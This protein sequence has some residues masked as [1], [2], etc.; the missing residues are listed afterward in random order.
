MENQNTVVEIIRGDLSDI[1]K[2]VFKD[3]KY[4]GEAMVLNGS[5]MFLVTPYL[6]IGMTYL[7]SIKLQLPAVWNGTAQV[8]TGIAVILLLAN[9]A[10]VYI[11]AGIQKACPQSMLG[12]LMALFN[13]CSNLILPIGIWVHGIIHEKYVSHLH[14]I[15]LTISILTILTAIKGKSVYFK[16]Q[17]DSKNHTS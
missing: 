4:I 15:F 14:F 2:L 6:S 17:N 10:G 1:L 9:M 13:A 5:L 16:L 3:K 7:I 8:I 11:I 12:R